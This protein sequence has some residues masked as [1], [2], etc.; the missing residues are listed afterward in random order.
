MLEAEVYI[1]GGDTIIIQE[2]T[3]NQMKV[4]ISRLMHAVIGRRT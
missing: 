2:K 4:I 1:R 3:S